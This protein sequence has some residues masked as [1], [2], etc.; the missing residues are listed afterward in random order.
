MN[1]TNNEINSTLINK[2]GFNGMC[3][4]K[5]ALYN[6]AIGLSKRNIHLNDEQLLDI[7]YQQLTENVK[8]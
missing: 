4:I 5:E 1:T 8:L 7:L 3:D 6:I 2:Y